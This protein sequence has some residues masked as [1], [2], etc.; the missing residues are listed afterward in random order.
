[1]NKG[2]AQV[3]VNELTGKRDRRGLLYTCEI[4]HHEQASHPEPVYDKQVVVAS[5]A[6]NPAVHE[7]I[8]TGYRTVQAPPS[9][10]VVVT[11][12]SGKRS[13]A[14][15]YPWKRADATGESRAK[16]PA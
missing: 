3:L 5:D 9:Y 15:V 16:A 12:R 7:Y 4:V 6:D 14:L 10:S 2:D 8:Q 11:H 1:M 13:T